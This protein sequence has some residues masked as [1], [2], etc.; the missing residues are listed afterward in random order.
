MD[1]ELKKLVN[2]PHDQLSRVDRMRKKLV[3][4][5]PGVFIY[6]LLFKGGILDG[7]HG[8]YYALQRFVAESLLSLKLLEHRFCSARVKESVEQ[9]PA[10]TAAGGPRF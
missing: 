8:W 1:Y 3:M 10:E 5:P 7:W 4:V 6:S 9:L 2:T